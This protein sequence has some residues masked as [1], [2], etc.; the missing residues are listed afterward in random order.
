VE[1]KQLKVVLVLKSRQVEAGQEGK[2]VQKERG[3][4]KVDRGVRDRAK[5][6]VPASQGGQL[7]KVNPAVGVVDQEIG[8]LV[9]GWAPGN[10]AVEPVGRA[11]RNQVKE[12]ALKSPAVELLVV[13]YSQ[14]STS[15]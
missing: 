1:A 8:N 12:Q 13:G 15:I 9:K 6:R 3:Q 11:A 7:L 2:V 10:L 5:R 14:K 4:I